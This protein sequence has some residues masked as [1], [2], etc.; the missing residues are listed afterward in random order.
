M[1]EKKL[2]IFQKISKVM[3]DIEYLQKDDKVITN[4]KSGTGYKAIT[5]EKVTSEVRKSLIKNGIVIIP[6]E[7][8]HKRE[9]EVLTDQY[10]NEKNNRL[11]TVDTIYRIQNIDDKEDY[12]EAVSSGTGVDTQDKGI[13]KAMTYSY[14]Y[15]LLRTFAIPTGEDA[16]K[17]SSEMY[18]E[19]FSTTKA[20]KKTTSVTTEK[21]VMIQESQ[22]TKIKEI[23]S[24]EQIKKACEMIGKDKLE[25][26]TIQEAS[27]LIKKFTKE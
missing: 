27:S 5:E 24:E 9:D 3:A 1:E 4:S 2:N 16:D 19:Q 6:V 15:L 14:K 8:K 17:I 10:G 18:S 12:I 26:F 21:V 13:G 25:D 11:T 22:I 20:K 23:L 7:Q